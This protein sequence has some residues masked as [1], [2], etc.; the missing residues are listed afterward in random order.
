MITAQILENNGT[1]KLTIQCDKK[2]FKGDLIE[3]KEIRNQSE[4]WKTIYK[5]RALWNILIDEFTER[6][7]QQWSRNQVELEFK[8]I[9]Q[10]FEL[11]YIKSLRMDNILPISWDNDNFEKGIMTLEKASKCFNLVLEFLKNSYTDI[12]FEFKSKYEYITNKNL[13]VFGDV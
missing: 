4:E 2:R 6:N 8:I 13:A 3:I 9:G 5:L 11:F 10:C 12:Y 7:D 1:G